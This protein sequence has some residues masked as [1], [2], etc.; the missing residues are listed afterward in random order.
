MAPHLEKKHMCWKRRLPNTKQ[1]RAESLKRHDFLSIDFL[2]G[3]QNMKPINDLIC[4]PY[5]LLQT[6][7]AQTW[8]NKA[9]SLLFN[10]KICL[11]TW[12]TNLYNLDIM[13]YDATHPGS[14]FSFLIG[15]CAILWPIQSSV[16]AVLPLPND[17]IWS[18]HSWI[19]LSDPLWIVLLM[20]DVAMC[21][22]LIYCFK[23]LQSP[24]RV[25]PLPQHTSHLELLSPTQSL[26]AS[27]RRLQEYAFFSNSISKSRPDKGIPIVSSLLS[28]I[29]VQ[30]PLFTAIH[31][32]QECIL[33]S[34]SFRRT[35]WVFFFLNPASTGEK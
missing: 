2:W 3:Q 28:H 21:P 16:C 15:G 32:Y 22:L 17:R 13:A 24:A 35:S 19:F 14:F 25:V 4:C 5:G 26:T 34:G 8:S 10:L 12:Q 20:S 30:V 7:I 6:S 18:V 27:L 33:E 1:S 23:L 9:T 31:R 11:H 29:H